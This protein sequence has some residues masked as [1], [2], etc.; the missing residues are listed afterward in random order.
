[1]RAELL[2]NAPKSAQKRVDDESG[3]NGKRRVA[4]ASVPRVPE[5]HEK[6]EKPGFTDQGERNA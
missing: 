1:M 2:E 5:A 6:L 3:A 4:T